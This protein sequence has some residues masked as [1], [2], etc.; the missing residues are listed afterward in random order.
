MNIT[1]TPAQL[2]FIDAIRTYGPAMGLDITQEKYTRESMRQVALKFKG[3]KRIPDWIARD[4]A[5]RG[6]RGIFLI[7]EVAAPAQAPEAT[8]EATAAPV[9]EA[10]ESVREMASAI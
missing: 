5:R 6:E 2:A 3:N 10:L 9:A 7:P 1:L 8:D 4:L